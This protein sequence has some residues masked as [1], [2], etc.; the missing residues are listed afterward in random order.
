MHAWHTHLGKRHRPP[1]LLWG[2]PSCRFNLESFLEDK[3]WTER[4]EYR[5]NPATSSSQ[6]CWTRGHKHQRRRVGSREREKQHLIW[7]RRVAFRPNHEI[8]L[9]YLPLRMAGLWVTRHFLKKI[10]TSK[11]IAHTASAWLND[12]RTAFTK[13]NPPTVPCRSICPVVLV[14]DNAMDGFCAW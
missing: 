10:E 11:F 12:G 7:K 4:G 1:P 13:C 3:S 6:G 9:I 8:F 5:D 14:A 2:S